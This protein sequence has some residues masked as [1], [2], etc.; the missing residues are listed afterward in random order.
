MPQRIDARLVAWLVRKRVVRRDRPIV[1]ETNG[2][3]G[4]VVGIGRAEHIRAGSRRADRHVE[5]PVTTEADS[6]RLGTCRSRFEDV[7]DISELFA[8]PSSSCEGGFV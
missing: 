2:L 3:A 6:R 8:I 1:A 5:H 7:A 4:I